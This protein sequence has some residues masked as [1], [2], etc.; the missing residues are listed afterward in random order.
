MSGG[1]LKEQLDEVQFFSEKR[2]KLYTA[3]IVLAIQFLHQHG[4]LHRDLKLENVLVGSDGHC[5][6]ADFGLSKLRLF[7]HCKTRTKCGM[8]FC[9][10]PEIVKNL[11]YG[12]GVDR[13]AVGVMIF[14]MMRG[15]PPFY[16]DDGEDMDDDNS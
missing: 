13:W 4:I 3:E 15:H 11:L 1:N 9:I 2:A 8:P 12:Q 16:Y 10:A 7:R 6:I 14:E 5:K